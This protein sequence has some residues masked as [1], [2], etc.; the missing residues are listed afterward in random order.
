ML[1]AVGLALSGQEWTGDDWVYRVRAGVGSLGTLRD[2]YVAKAA[3]AK[4]PGPVAVN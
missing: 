2:D 1:G 3:K 4:V